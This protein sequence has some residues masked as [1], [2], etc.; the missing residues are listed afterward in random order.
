MIVLLLDPFPNSPSATDSKKAA[1]G[2]Q[3]PTVGRARELRAV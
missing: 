2:M 3:G 1:I